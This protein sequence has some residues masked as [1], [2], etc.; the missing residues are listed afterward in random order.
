[1]SVPA[2][3][4]VTSE[5]FV[6]FTS[7]IFA[8]LGLRALYFLLAGVMARFE[9]LSVGLAFVLIFVGVKM[10]GVIPIS[11]AASL[12]V[13]TAILAAAIGFS[14]WKTRGESP[15]PEATA[16]SEIVEKPE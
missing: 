7:N 8:I 4:A 16:A 10:L 11:I 12:L 5:R 2:I 13:I 14:L 15:A 3:F 9:Y 6:I 1:D